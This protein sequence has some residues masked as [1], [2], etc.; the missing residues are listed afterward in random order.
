MDGRMD[1]QNFSLLELL[2]NYPL[3][4]YS[5]KE[6][7]KGAADLMMPFSNWF[8]FIIFFPDISSLHQFVVFNISWP[9]IFC[10][11]MLLLLI[12]LH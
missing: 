9:Y 11:E 8:L 7:G 6:Q 3:N 4:R 12:W 5:I 1:R 10:T 2:P